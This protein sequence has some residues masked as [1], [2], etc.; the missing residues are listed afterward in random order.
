MD[1]QG[2]YARAIIRAAARVGGN[3][4]LAERLQVRLSDLEQWLDGS[5]FPPMPVF[6]RII[7]IALD[8]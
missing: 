4:A 3:A 1:N 2:V 5:E 6:L 8:G 7:A